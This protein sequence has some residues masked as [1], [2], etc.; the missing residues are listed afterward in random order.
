M[1][2][3]WIFDVDEIGFGFILLHACLDGRRGK[4]VGFELYEC[5]G[6]GW[7]SSQS[8]IITAWLCQPEAEY[9]YKLRGDWFYLLLWFQPPVAEY[10]VLVEIF[11]CPPYRGDA[12]EIFSDRDSSGGVTI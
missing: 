1:D 5:S 11:D 10:L 4:F 2:V 12:A 8:I 3:V 9:I 7:I 6:V